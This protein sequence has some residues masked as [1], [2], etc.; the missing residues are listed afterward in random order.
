MNNPLQ[1]SLLVISDGL[2]LAYTSTKNRI[3]KPKKYSGSIDD[4]CRNIINDC[5]NKKKKYLMVSPNNFRQ[6][7]ARDFGMC[8]ESLIKIGYKDEVRQTLVYAMNIY[9]KKGKITT[10][11]TPFGAPTDFPSHTPESAS[12]MLNSL[13]LLD[14]KNLI[15]QH[16][17]FFREIGEY[18]YN[19]DIDKVTGLLRKDK[20]FSSMKDHALRKSDC[21]NNCF[22]ALFA[23]NLK[24]IKV[25]SSLA[26]YDY[27]KTIADNFL[28][29]ENYFLEDLS[30]RNVFSGDA[31]TFPFWTGLFDCRGSTKES[32]ENRELFKKIIKKIQE[33]KLDSPWPLRYTTKEDAPKN[34]HIANFFCPGY[35]T[36]TLWIHLG[37][38]YM[39][40]IN[41]VDKK[42]LRQYLNEYES[43]IQ[44]HNTFYEVYDTDGKVYSRAFYRADETMIWCSIFLDLYLENKKK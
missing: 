39:K 40:A 3:F 9:A 14:D 11:I 1:N 31:N 24:K 30:G 15:N 8:C 10:H 12:Y 32:K 41:P 25:D 20:H 42:L 28:T 5:F 23:N 34:L 43:L 6:F 38:C 4:I 44:K 18:I 27:K 16:K 17:E 37:L 2:R 21:Y 19:N 22:L 13:I 35:E 7:Y 33:K 26:K 36:D 29:T